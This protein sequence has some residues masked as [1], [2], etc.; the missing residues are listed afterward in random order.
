MNPWAKG[1]KGANKLVL[2]Q[3]CGGESKRR[4]L[5]ISA[6]PDYRSFA[7]CPRCKKWGELNFHADQI[8]KGDY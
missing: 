4:D 6:G 1:G 2:C 8:L 3:F 7:Q 5:A